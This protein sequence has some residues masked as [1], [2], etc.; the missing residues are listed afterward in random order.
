MLN[1]TTVLLFVLKK[2]CKYVEGLLEQ[3]FDDQ[4]EMSEDNYRLASNLSQPE[5][6][7][8]QSLE[9]C[10][11]NQESFV[12]CLDKFL[13]VILMIRNCRYY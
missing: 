3:H 12:F 13:L 2:F 4:V 10:S 11:R 9:K 1:H 6:W 8:Q 5:V 7:I